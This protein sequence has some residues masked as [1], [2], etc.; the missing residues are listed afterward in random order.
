MT[1]MGLLLVLAL[2]VFRPAMRRLN[3]SLATRSD[4]L[5]RISH[6]VRNPMSCITWHGGYPEKHQ[7][8]LPSSSST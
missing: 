2:F 6:G 3:A 8:E 4:F 7:L 5:S 1:L